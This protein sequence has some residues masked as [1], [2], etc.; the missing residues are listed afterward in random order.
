[1]VVQQNLRAILANTAVK[2]TSWGG[3]DSSPSKNGLGI[4]TDTAEEVEDDGLLTSSSQYFELFLSGP[5]AICPSCVSVKPRE[6]M[7]AIATMNCGHW[8]NYAT[9]RV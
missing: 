4:N 1:M 9:V 8:W 6:R 7:W 2:R 3:G 5:D